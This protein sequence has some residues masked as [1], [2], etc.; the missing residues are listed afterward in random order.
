M[1]EIL[2]YLTTCS[3][4]FD[5]TA[6]YPVGDRALRRLFRAYPTND[7]IESVLLKVA[8]LNALYRTQILDVYGMAEHVLRQR[9]DSHL[10]HGSL[11]L[12]NLLRKFRGRDY[13]SFSTKYCHWHRP[14]VYPM[15][16]RYVAVALQ[17]LNQRLGVGMDLAWER[18]RDYGLFVRAVDGCRRT[19]GL[20]WKGY[21][22]FDQA[23]WILGQRIEEE[24]DP[25][26][27][28]FVGP[29]PD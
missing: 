24:A 16:D 19:A 1:K 9:I 28:R 15:Y 8:A 20:D 11:E 6:D 3:A 2:D 13:Y 25:A 10:K 4:A 14:G 26:V 17:W 5:Q 18:L 23:L 22:R 29:L 12:V 27:T 21:K 7:E